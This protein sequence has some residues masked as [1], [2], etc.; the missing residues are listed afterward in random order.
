MRRRQGIHFC[1]VVF[2]LFGFFFFLCFFFCS[3]IPTY[4]VPIHV[5]EMS[6]PRRY[7]GL[8]VTRGLRG[9]KGNCTDARYLCVAL[10]DTKGGRMNEM[11]CGIRR[12]SGPLTICCRLDVG[13]QESCLHP[14]RM[15]MR[16]KWL[17]IASVPLMHGKKGSA[18]SS[19]PWRSLS[20]FYITG[21]IS[22]RIDSIA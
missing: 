16:K 4:R 8:V 20:E 22:G 19:R 13:G 1:C 2:V 12:D 10:A 18:S 14:K 7:G 5:P 3:T 9:S 17:E 11:R 15:S 6:S 21:R